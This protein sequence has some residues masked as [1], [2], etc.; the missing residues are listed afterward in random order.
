MSSQWDI[1][2]G[3]WARSMHFD[4]HALAVRASSS[5]RLG[6]HLDFDSAIL[7]KMLL[8]QTKFVQF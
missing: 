2:L 4:A 3:P 6:D 5:V 1:A 7:L 8:K